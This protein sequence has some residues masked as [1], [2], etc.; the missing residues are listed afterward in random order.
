MQKD[1]VNAKLVIVGE[2]MELEK[3]YKLTINDLVR[4]ADD[5]T[6]AEITQAFQAIIGPVVVRAEVTQTHEISI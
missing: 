6:V 2:D 5:Q 1:F 3:D 4:D